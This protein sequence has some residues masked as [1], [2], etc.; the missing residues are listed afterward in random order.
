MAFLSRP[1]N[2]LEKE[3]RLMMAYFS[4]FDGATSWA[5]IE[6]VV[7]RTFHD[8]LHVEEGGDTFDRAQFKAKIQKFVEEG[9]SMEILKLKAQPLGIV[10][11]LTFHKPGSKDY[12]T[13][14]FG[15]FQDGK[16]IRVQRDNVRKAYPIL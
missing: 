14:S 8:D 11:H 9:G 2:N 5:D 15:T 4:V 13:K 3:M 16:L 7:E 6:P 12:P 1:K 10:Y